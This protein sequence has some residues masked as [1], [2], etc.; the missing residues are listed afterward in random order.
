MGEI[1]CYS[2]AHKYG[3]MHMLIEI[4]VPTSVTY[5]YDG[6]DTTFKVALKVVWRERKRIDIRLGEL[7][8]AN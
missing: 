8:D 5:T 2:Y 1:K 4:Q 3:C 6:D 7:Q